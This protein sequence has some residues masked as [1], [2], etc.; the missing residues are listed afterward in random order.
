MLYSSVGFAKAKCMAE[1]PDEIGE[2]FADEWGVEHAIAEYNTK[3]GKG[4][5]IEIVGCP[6]AEDSAIDS[7]Q[8]PDPHRPE[9]YTQVERLVRRFKDE[10]WVTGGTPLTILETAFALRGR[11][12]LL[13][14]LG[15]DHDLV[16]RLLKI[17]YDYHLVAA[18]KLID[19]GV[20][21][22]RLADDVGS[23]NAM[24]IS[25]HTWRR[26]PKPLMAEFILTLRRVNPQVVI[27]YHSDGLIYSIIPDL[28]E[29]GVDVLNPI[30]PLCMD[31]ERLKREYGEHLCFW[32][33]LDVQYTLP[34]G[35][36]EDV[37]KEVIT[38]LKTIGKD[39][40]LII[41]PSH[42]VQLDTPPESF[43]A[44]VDTTM[45]TPYSSLR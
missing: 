4:R 39:G 1:Q 3:F 28:I 32:G 22:L 33:S 36:P 12:R 16:E 11:E 15:T 21:M 31:P 37:R 40:G 5:Y 26:F 27:A 13:M 41:G 6:L 7:Y 35:T 44:M 29:I 18:Q 34:C 24:M 42:M 30:Q 38:R 9:L 2:V 19:L 20:D 45:N 17:P 8:A 23:Q 14:D 43:W 25:P 10:Y